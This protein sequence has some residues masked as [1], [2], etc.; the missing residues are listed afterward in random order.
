MPSG[1]QTCSFRFCRR[2]TTSPDLWRFKALMNPTGLATVI[3]VTSEHSSFH[4]SVNL[5]LNRQGEALFK[6]GRTH[7][8]V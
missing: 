1:A 5:L 3:T 4:P 7:Q 6:L 8:T 2:Q